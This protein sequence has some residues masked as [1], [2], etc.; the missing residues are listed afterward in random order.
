MQAE[1]NKGGQGGDT[2]T[3]SAGAATCDDNIARDQGGAAM[4]KRLRVQVGLLSSKAA[5]AVAAC[6]GTAS[7]ATHHCFSCFVGKVSVLL[8]LFLAWHRSGLFLA[9]R[10]P[11]GFA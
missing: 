4:E 3:T 7:S 2:I 5:G 1:R 11:D 8:S 10:R 9:K 6:D